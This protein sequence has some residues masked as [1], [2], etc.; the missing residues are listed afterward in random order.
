MSYKKMMEQ[1]P[2]FRFQ[3]S[4]TKDEVLSLFAGCQYPNLLAEKIAGNGYGTER[5]AQAAGISCEEMNAI[6]AGHGNLSEQ[7]RERI[8][9]L[10][11][12]HRGQRT[13]NYLFSNHLACDNLFERKGKEA[14]KRSLRRFS[15]LMLDIYQAYSLYPIPEKNKIVGEW[16]WDLTMDKLREP[17]NIF[18]TGIYLYAEQYLVDWFIN[19]V[20]GQLYFIEQSARSRGIQIQPRASE[21]TKYSRK[22]ADAI[23]YAILRDKLE[24]AVHQHELKIMDALHRAR[25][26]AI[27]QVN[28]ASARERLVSVA[29]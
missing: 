26:E 15:N 19:W 21:S 20:C 2:D 28:E 29:S 4:T 6:M 13:Q 3:A 23:A 25:K 12:E 11:N 18:Q 27:Q 16:R 24:D 22:M 10:Y 17:E 1:R 7:Q 5:L 9:T 8:Q 14:A